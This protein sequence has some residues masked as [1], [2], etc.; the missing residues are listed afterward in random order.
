MYLM[1]RISGSSISS[2]RTPQ[3]VPVILLTFGFK[4][5][6]SSKNSFSSYLGSLSHSACVTSANWRSIRIRQLPL[7]FANSISKG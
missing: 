5:G 4:A 6:A 7:V 2:S 3:I 1:L